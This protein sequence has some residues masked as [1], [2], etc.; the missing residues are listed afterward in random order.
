MFRCLI[1]STIEEM[2]RTAIAWRAQGYIVYTRHTER[3]GWE[4]LAAAP[5]AVKYLGAKELG[6]CLR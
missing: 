5:A 3:G 4:L 2:E 1:F 6:G